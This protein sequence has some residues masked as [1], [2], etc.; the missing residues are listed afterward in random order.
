[1]TASVSP[2]A[3]LSA[4][5]TVT[6]TVPSHGAATG[7][8]IF[9]TSMTRISSPFATFCPFVAVTRRTVPGTGAFTS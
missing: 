9:M 2:V 6:V 5:L 1:M 4:A 7:V 8:S 3:T